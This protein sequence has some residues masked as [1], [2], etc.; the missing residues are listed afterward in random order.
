MLYIHAQDCPLSNLNVL[1]E[2]VFPI[3]NHLYEQKNINDLTKVIDS[4]LEYTNKMLD[5]YEFIKADVLRISLQRF[6]GDFAFQVLDEDLMDKTKS[7]Q[8]RK[9]FYKP[10][11]KIGQIKAELFQKFKGTFNQKMGKYVAHLQDKVVYHKPPHA[12]LTAG[13]LEINKIDDNYR[14]QFLLN[15]SFPEQY[16]KVDENGVSVEKNNLREW[17]ALFNVFLVKRDDAN[18]RLGEIYKNATLYN[19]KGNFV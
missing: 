13:R 14:C 18:A 10:Y 7:E 9:S 15:P 19:R 11:D 17:D 2:E 8:Y 4:I 16:K 1:F 3:I 6:V 5:N 12:S